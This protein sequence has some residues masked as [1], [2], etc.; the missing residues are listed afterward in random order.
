MEKQHLNYT[1]TKERILKDLRYYD[2]KVTGMEEEIKSLSIH[3]SNHK[4]QLLVCQY[5]LRK[6]D[7]DLSN[8]TFGG[9]NSNGKL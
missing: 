2:C 4:E 8:G 9:G 6:L 5:L 1:T 7:E 3:L